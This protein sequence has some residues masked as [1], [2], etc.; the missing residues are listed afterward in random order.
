MNPEQRKIIFLIGLISLA[1]TIHL[2]A[3]EIIKDGDTYKTTVKNEFQVKP[4]GKLIMKR[5]AGD[6]TV[7]SWTKNQVYIEEMLQMSVFTREEADKILE[8]T[9]SQYS[10]QGNTIIVD[11]SE[12]K[13]WI[14]RKFSVK[15]PEQFNL[16]VQTSGGD[17]TVD[18]LTG[19]VDLTTSGGDIRVNQI[20]GAVS[21]QTSGGDLKL[22]EIKGPL[23]AKTSGGDI[24][25]QNLKDNVTAKTS[26][27][28]IRLAD[29]QSNVE[30]KTSG[31][32]IT[33][34]KVGGALSAATSGGTI[35]VSDCQGKVDVHTSGGD[36]LLKN[37][38]G[39]LEGH[40]SGGD[41]QG[42]DFSNPLNLH[43][44]GGD[45]GIKNLRSGI[46]ARTSAGEIKV[47]MTLSDFEQP[48]TIDL[49]TSAGTID[50]TIPARLPATITAEIHLGDGKRY[51]DRYDIYSD[52]P[53]AKNKIEENGKQIIRSTGE[54]N[55]GGDPIKLQTSA[56]DIRIRE[57]K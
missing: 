13:R 43:T 21:V 19:N 49:C 37:I 47:E 56:G 16:D 15:L 26:G 4:G 2:P 45:I 18:V 57:G 8:H 29:A 30:L 36:I 9:K 5:I 14:Q 33:V 34:T 51:W 6:V 27:G 46:S 53:L 32:D 12:G 23:D 39:Q 20:D 54:I 52:F 50:L 35:D 55:G 41:I 11:G 48:H 31:G 38:G 1:M 25:L 3:Q 42:F 44:S 7:S 24:R 40:T 22:V 28:S 10:Q 17:L